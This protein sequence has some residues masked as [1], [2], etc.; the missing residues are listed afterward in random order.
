QSLRMLD[1]LAERRSLPEVT[2]DPLQAR[3]GDEI[4][5]GWEVSEILGKGATSRAL[6]MRHD[7]TGREIVCKVA[8]NTGSAATAL[9]SEAQALRVVGHHPR[10]VSMP[11]SE[12]GA[13]PGIEV[14]GD[15]TFLV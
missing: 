3:T 12:K 5:P 7:H 10:I 1:E 2:T 11:S 8:L 15:R 9:R 13:E 14:I 4:T 6:L